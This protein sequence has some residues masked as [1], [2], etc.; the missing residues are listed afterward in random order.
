MI[1][2]ATI[3]AAAALIGPICFALGWLAR[4]ERSYQL[5]YDHGHD[6]G[7]A[8]AYADGYEQGRHDERLSQ[9]NPDV[10]YIELNG[11]DDQEVTR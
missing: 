5:G 4:H 9:W 3:A 8:D 11:T 1:L 6:M 10:G 2:A 7:R